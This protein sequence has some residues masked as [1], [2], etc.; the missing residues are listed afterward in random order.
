MDDVQD[1]ASEEAGEAVPAPHS[2]PPEAVQLLLEEIRGLAAIAETLEALQR[3]TAQLVRRDM[4]GY[5]WVG[6]YMVDPADE[7]FLLLGPYSGAQTDHTRIPVSEGICGAAVATGE[8]MVIDDV[9]ADPR[10]LSCSIE[11]QSEIVVPIRVEGKIVGE[12]DIDSHRP[13]AFGFDDRAFVETWAL[14]IGDWMTD[15]LLIE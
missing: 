6:F 2:G 8:T 5:D 14:I 3:E 15:Q 7:N 9:H 11:T 1:I 4:P 12:I 10:Y 13:A